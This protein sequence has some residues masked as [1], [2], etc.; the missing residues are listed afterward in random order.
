M[1]C[2]EC[3]SKWNAENGYCPVCRREIGSYNTEIIK[4]IDNFVKSTNKTNDEKCFKFQNENDFMC[5]KIV[6]NII[7]QYK[8]DIQRFDIPS[9]VRGLKQQ[10]E[11]VQKKNT[12][13]KDKLNFV[14]VQREL[15][16]TFSK[17]LV[18]QVNELTEKVDKSQEKIEDL[19]FLLEQSNDK[20]YFFK[21]RKR[22]LENELFE[23]IL[24]KFGLQSNKII[25]DDIKFFEGVVNLINSKHFDECNRK[26]TI[27]FLTSGFVFNGFAVGLDYILFNVFKKFVSRQATGLYLAQVVYILN[28]GIVS[29]LDRMMA[30]YFLRH[31]SPTNNKLKEN[32]EYFIAKL[33]NTAMKNR[34]KEFMRGFKSYTSN[35][36]F[37]LIV[38]CCNN[39]TD[40]YRTIISSPLPKELNQLKADSENKYVKEH[41]G[42]VLQWTD[43]GD[44]S[45]AGN[46]K[47]G[48]YEFSMNIRVALILLKF[49]ECDRVNIV[50]SI[51]DRSYVEKIA[52]IVSLEKIGL[53]TNVQKNIYEINKKFYYAQKFIE[54][55]IPKVN[56]AKKIKSM[57]SADYV[58]ERNVHK[59]IFYLM[60]LNYTDLNTVSLAVIR[61]RVIQRIKKYY[62]KTPFPIPME[63]FISIRRIEKELYDLYDQNYID[64]RKYSEKGDLVSIQL[65]V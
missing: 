12:E 60:G 2:K 14:T 10:V 15:L 28:I 27:Q 5:G 52:I 41:S 64:L 61:N 33:K 48:C 58:L 36:Q 6:N 16:D 17:K 21:S 65:F 45:L 44:C 22:E 25:K 13:L 34:I 3:I 23:F 49:N 8:K 9:Q 31:G 62:P 1:F 56:R 26:F 54:I 7:S 53:I 20:N 24:E 30:L 19:S 59:V 46:F 39:T 63:M 38:V 42:R 40:N 37:N 47:S 50:N 35:K 4:V 43:I 18:N 51:S 29:D 55:N 57:V 11:E 32:L